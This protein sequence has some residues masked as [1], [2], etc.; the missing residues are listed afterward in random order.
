M[1]WI[2]IFFLHFLSYIFRFS[3]LSKARTIRSQYLDGGTPMVDR[4]M[5]VWREF[6]G[7]G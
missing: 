7:L 4:N 3:L 6:Q 2:D 5:P 1:A